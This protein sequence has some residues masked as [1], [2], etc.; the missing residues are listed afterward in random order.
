MQTTSITGA[1]AS[2]AIEALQAARIVSRV[3]VSAAVA[4]V[5]ARLAYGTERRD[6]DLLLVGVVA[7]RVGASARRG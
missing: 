5:L 3:R 4:D 2:P 7:E 6:H 1:T